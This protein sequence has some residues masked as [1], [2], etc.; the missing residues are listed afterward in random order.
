MRYPYVTMRCIFLRSLVVYG[1][2]VI[3]SGNVIGDGNFSIFNLQLSN[4]QLSTFN[5]LISM[6]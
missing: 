4:F 2:N 3:G 1:P 6:A 5:H